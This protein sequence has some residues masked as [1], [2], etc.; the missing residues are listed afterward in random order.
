MTEAD[1]AAEEVIV[2]GLARAFPGHA[3]R[4][5]EGA[6]VEGTEGTW[7]IDPIDGT[8]AF[9]EELAYW[10]PTI[11]LVRDGRLEVGALWLPRLQ[12]FWYAVRGVGAFRDGK[13][14]RPAP[15]E[16]VDR[17]ASLYLPS[18]YHHRAPIPWPGKVRGLGSTAVHLAQVAAG[19]AALTVVAAAIILF[20]C[21]YPGRALDLLGRH[22]GGIEGTLLAQLSPLGWDRINLTGDY[23]GSDTIPLDQDGLMPL[24]TFASAIRSPALS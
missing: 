24:E 23:V 20:D 12:E 2:E 16:R 22:A 3:I 6:A 19:G 15:L 5:E 10:G 7:Y 1:Q 18:R 9:L 14:L 4:G 17:N 13:R 8:S 21:R 11:C